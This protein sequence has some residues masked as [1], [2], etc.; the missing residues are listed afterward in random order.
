MDTKQVSAKLKLSLRE[1]VLYVTRKDTNPLS[2]EQRNGTLNLDNKNLLVG[3][4]T[5]GIDV[6]FMENM[7]TLDQIA[8]KII[9]EKETQM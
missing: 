3:I 1:N 9:S 8:L 4:T 5:H 2:V 7:G 6:T